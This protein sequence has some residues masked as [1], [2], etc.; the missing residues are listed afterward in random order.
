[1]A[2]KIG[3]ENQFIRTIAPP[4]VTETFSSRLV[5][6]VDPHII[7]GDAKTRFYTEVNTNLTTEDKVFIINGNYCNSKLNEEYLYN[8]FSTGYKIL[9]V[10]RNSITLDLDYSAILPKKDADFNNTD[11]FIK[12]YVVNKTR[13]VD[14]YDYVMK[15]PKLES[16]GIAKFQ[17]F[18]TFPSATLYEIIYNN[19]GVSISSPNGVI[20]AD[21]FY[22]YIL[23]SGVRNKIPVTP[24]E[25]IN[26]MDESIGKKLFAMESFEIIAGIINNN[27]LIFEKGKVYKYGVG[28]VTIDI[29]YEDTFLSRSN[30]RFGNFKSGNWNDGIFGKKLS[31]GSEKRPHWE[32]AKW[33]NGIFYN[34]DW[35]SGT[36]ES[37]S[38]GINQQSFYGDLDEFN[39]IKQSTDFTNNKTFGYNYVFESDVT[40]AVIK[41]GNIFNTSFGTMSTSPSVR[42]EYYLGGTNSSNL[43]IEGGLYLGSDFAYANIFGGTFELSDIENSNVDGV[44]ILDSKINNS[45]ITDSEYDAFGS[46]KIA[47]YDRQF[48]RLEEAGLKRIG[49][50]HK[51]YVSDE[52]YLKINEGDSIAFNNLITDHLG[53]ETLFDKE[54]FIGVG[55]IANT[56]GFNHGYLDNNHEVIVDLRP[57]STNV[58]KYELDTATSSFIVNTVPNDKLYNSIDLTFMVSYLEPTITGTYSTSNL[59]A[60]LKNNYEY[61]YNELVQKNEDYRSSVTIH[62]G[63]KIQISKLSNSLFDDSTWLRGTKEN[64]EDYTISYSGGFGSFEPNINITGTFGFYGLTVGLTYS[65]NRNLFDYNELTDEVIQL[66]N[67]TY[68]QGTQSYDISGSYKVSNVISG[69]PV[70]LVD[71]SEYGT[72]SP[73][74]VGVTFSAGTFSYHNSSF[75]SNSVFDLDIDN[76]TISGGKFRRQ[77]F[78]NSTIFNKDINIL[79]KSLL[80]ANLNNLKIYRSMLSGSDNLVVKDSFLHQSVLESATVSNAL[81][82]NSLMYDTVWN[83]GL[84][85][86]SHWNSGLFNNGIF[87][88]LG[89]RGLDGL[90][91]W[92]FDKSSK[93]PGPLTFESISLW[94]DGTFN[95]GELFDT[96]WKDGTFNDGKF[97]KSRWEDGTFNDGVFGD[98]NLN[99]SDTHFLQGTWNN[100]IFN[101]GIFGYISKFP[102]VTTS[103]WNDG[104]FNDGVF[105]GSLFIVGN[106]PIGNTIWNNGTFNKGEFSGSARWKDGIFNG[107]KFKSVWG[108]GTGPSASNYGWEYGTFNNGEFGD[109]G[110]TSGTTWNSTWY[111]GIFEGG[112]F[113]GK[114]WNNGFFTG[115]KFLGMTGNGASSSNHF[116]DASMSAVSHP[117]NFVMSFSTEAS[118]KNWYGLWRRGTVIDNISD[119]NN[120]IDSKFKD[121][122]LFKGERAPLIEFENALWVDGTFSSTSGQMLNSIWLNGQFDRGTFIESNFNPYVPRWDFNNDGGASQSS[123]NGKYMHSLTSSCVWNNGTFDNSIFQ[124]SS[125]NNGNFLY[126]TMSNS[127]FNNGVSNY[128]NAYNVIWNDGR[129]RN[130]NW[131]GADNSIVNY[132]DLT[133]TLGGTS[134]LWFGNNS[135]NNDGIVHQ[136]RRHNS[137]YGFLWDIFGIDGEYMANPTTQQ[138]KNNDYYNLNLAGN[139]LTDPLGTFTIAY[140]VE[141]QGY[142]A[143][144][145]PTSD[146][147]IVADNFSAVSLTASLQVDGFTVESKFGNGAF[148]KGTWENGVWNN[149]ARDIFWDNVEDIKLFDTVTYYQLSKDVWQIVLTG[150]DIS[151]INSFK[152]GDDISIGNIVLIDINGKRKLIKDK[153]KIISIDTDNNYLYVN[154][155]INFPIRKIQRDSVRHKIKVT[156][157]IWL[158][159]LFLNGKFEGIWNNGYFKGYPCVTEMIR[160]NWIDGTFD[161]GHF[162]A[163]TATYSDSITGTSSFDTYSTGLVQNFK[164]F[165]NI[166]DETT[167]A[168]SD[169]PIIINRFDSWMDINYISPNGYDSENFQLSSI[170]LSPSID[171]QTFLNTNPYI[172]GSNTTNDVISSVS[173]FLTKSSVFENLS[174]GIDIEDFDNILT[175]SISSFDDILF[176]DR[177]ETFGWSFSIDQKTAFGAFQ[178]PSTINVKIPG[179]GSLSASQ[180]VFLATDNTFLK[181]PPGSDNTG[182]PLN[183]MNIDIV[184]G[185]VNKYFVAHEN[186]VNLNKKRYSKVNFTFLE[187]NLQLL[188]TITDGYITPYPGGGVLEGGAY[189]NRFTQSGGVETTITKYFYNR[190]EREPLLAVG[191]ATGFGIKIDNLELIETD[192]IPFFDYALT[193]DSD[194]D[195]INCDV[196]IPFTAV[197]PFID[198]DDTD[199]SFIDNVAFEFAADAVVPTPPTPPVLQGEVNGGQQTN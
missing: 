49:I 194:D 118:N 46:I 77:F 45:I 7:G 170:A 159:G 96:T 190:G 180:S 83:N 21:S 197:A 187:Q 52:D 105:G 65:D 13:E 34:S 32:G 111:D 17:Y 19:T 43:T 133:G 95:K 81:V 109:I 178:F 6:Y 33:R 188:G 182:F 173:N 73:I 129:W 29:R 128:M 131:Y 140:N 127:E 94:L 82:Y 56:N 169:G 117:E 195:H 27:S 60:L 2:T 40:N 57:K 154:T 152:V 135:G 70:T 124:V 69:P 113:Q 90:D 71:L 183:H 78:N 9:A 39:I 92:F 193:I 18:P 10:E 68:T 5:N 11:E 80:T 75:L 143:F 1:M 79:D 196:R 122:R 59:I 137:T 85:L 50:V 107:G 186:Q 179:G 67:I 22:S 139:L 15:N 66:N 100:G 147:W 26:E 165:S 99:N 184:N 141:F 114:V 130:G 151:D 89:S 63:A 25:I 155:V 112:L 157:N 98:K 64:K 4:K 136:M 103:T 87:D 191:G 97:Y 28:G 164:F 47:D 150:S 168:L 175:D 167:V 148:K 162:L 149:G 158:S 146:L 41:N 53:V 54:Y 142:Q 108:S 115:G 31:L 51:F 185:N 125:W 58:N 42:E 144:G 163:D 174:L 55:P 189:V 156:K 30:F 3:T 181:P 12:V 38:D 88:G 86:G 176:P 198:Y 172:L 138:P 37:K 93:M 120:N 76:S 48:F 74:N 153:F 23:Q 14:Y 199:F 119:I 171:I 102:P 123:N 132:M 44:K 36:M 192:M 116:Y 166:E 20:P 16:G 84:L 110:A 24:S 35:I 160:S 161:G 104:T 72:Y 126:G 8:K 101:K 177:L 134:S 121:I 106:T 91:E 62:E 61:I 145:Y